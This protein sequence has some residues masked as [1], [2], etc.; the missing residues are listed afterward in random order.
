MTFGHNPPVPNP[1]VPS[2]PVPSLCPAR[3]QLVR[4]V[5]ARAQFVPCLL[6]PSSCRARSCPVRA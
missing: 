2:P 4:V 3:A 5:P 6:V 1:P